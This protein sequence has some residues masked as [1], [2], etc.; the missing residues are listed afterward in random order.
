MALTAVQ[1]ARAAAN[2]ARAL[3]LLHHKKSLRSL[4]AIRYVQAKRR[5]IISRR[6]TP[7]H[8]IMARSRPQKRRRGNRVYPPRLYRA[9]NLNRARRSYFNSIVKPRPSWRYKY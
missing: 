4:N 6:N 7:M 1:R 2:R 8:V 5:G 9:P 3:R